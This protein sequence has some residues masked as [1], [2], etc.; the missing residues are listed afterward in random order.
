MKLRFSTE[1]QLMKMNL[2]KLF[3]SLK[4]D[5]STCTYEAKKTFFPAR[6]YAI[7]SRVS[8][9]IS[10]VWKKSAIKYEWKI[11]KLCDARPLK[12][13]VE[14]KIPQTQKKRHKTTTEN[15]ECSRVHEALWQSQI[16]LVFVHS[17]DTK[18][19]SA[20]A[21]GAIRLKIDFE[22]ASAEGMKIHITNWG[23][24]N[25]CISFIMLHAH[26]ILCPLIPFSPKKC[27]L[28][29]PISSLCTRP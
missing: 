3:F 4:F 15:C 23:F 5:V 17:I 29:L 12:I 8:S 2:K 24:V 27:I 6:V 14:K 1:N 28:F 11:Q 19:K 21:F 13:Q 18:E 26:T 9:A 10:F 20:T 25:Y 16:H 7:H 22:N